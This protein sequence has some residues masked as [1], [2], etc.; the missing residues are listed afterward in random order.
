[1]QIFHKLL[2]L[3]NFVDGKFPVVRCSSGPDRDF[4]MKIRTGPLQGDLASDRLY[5]LAEQ[6]LNATR[7]KLRARPVRMREFG[8]HKY[9]EKWLVSNVRGVATY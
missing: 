7:E 4:I 8:D 6:R 1:M 2:S 9:L 5:V 3:D